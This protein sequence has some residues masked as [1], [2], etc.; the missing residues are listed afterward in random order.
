[1]SGV[2]CSPAVGAAIE[3]RQGS[4]LFHLSLQDQY[5]RHCESV[6]RLLQIEHPNIEMG[7]VLDCLTENSDHRAEAVE[8]L[9]SILPPK[10]KTA[11]LPLF[12]ERAQAPQ[13]R[14]VEMIRSLL[15]NGASEW[16][17]VGAL[18]WIGTNRLAELRDV[19]ERALE[20][21][22]ATVRQTAMAALERLDERSSHT[23][24]H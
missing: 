12:D 19:A 11:V 4:D 9:D 24:P 21:R 13:G 5:R 20:H 2:K 15:Q 16:V 22:S 23:P 6:L 10:R 8:L 18:Y 3:P 7:V 1:M 17:V 14:S